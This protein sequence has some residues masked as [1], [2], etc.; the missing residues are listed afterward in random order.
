M[1]TIIRH[2]VITLL[3]VATLATAAGAQGEVWTLDRA[4]AFALEQSPD[5]RIAGHRI[6]SAEAMVRQANSGYYPQ[7]GLE[8]SYMQTNT[9]MMAFGAILNQGVF[10]PAIDF[11]NP[12]QVDN[13][14]VTGRVGYNL[15]SGGQRAAGKTAA[16]AGLKASEYDNQSTRDQLAFEVV[17]AYFNIIKA[18]EVVASTQSAVAAFEENLKVARLKFEAGTFLKTEVLNL[19]VQLAQTRE[20]L[21]AF[22]HQRD[23]AERVFL[24]L[25]GLQSNQG[26]TLAA[27]DPSTRRL[28]PP[29]AVDPEMRSDLR[30]MQAR[31]EAAEAQVRMVKG[32][33][34]PTVNAFG[35]YQLDHGWRLD[36][37]GDSWMA[38]VA[39]NLNVFDGART[40]GKIEEAEAQFN[41]AREGLRKM[42]LGVSLQVEQARLALSQARQRLDVTAKVIEQAEESAVL[43]RARFEQGV[44]LS[45]DLINIETR[46]TEARMRR[47]I[48]VADERVAVAQ[49]RRAYG[50]EQF[51]N[52]STK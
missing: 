23:L 5:S 31:T 51:S 24:N 26:V 38:G 22:Q 46:L 48:A 9:P 18:R 34:M 45:S 43:S 50:L 17:N 6:R 7:V 3:A 15:Y 11:N 49:L 36:G 44:I 52:S 14:N 29:V 40:R 37:T 35:T 21:L 1:Q 39:V 42:T 27:D 10:S 33:R 20:N 16:E 19:E 13:L 47:A 12:G 4:V 32:E 28:V 25:L 2:T 30:A 8:A 41:E